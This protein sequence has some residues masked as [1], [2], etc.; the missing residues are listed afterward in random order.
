MKLTSLKDIILSGLFPILCF[1][2]AFIV[3]FFHPF[4]TY[5]LFYIIGKPQNIFPTL[6]FIKHVFGIGSIPAI[7]NSAENSH[8]SDVAWLIRG[9]ICFFILFLTLFLKF[10]G[11]NKAH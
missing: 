3:L 1:I 7:F 2:A 4:F 6:G 5:F 10:V 9:L 8:L 11:K